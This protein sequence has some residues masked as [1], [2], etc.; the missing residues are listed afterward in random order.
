[1]RSGECRLKIG[2]CFTFSVIQLTLN[3]M[4]HNITSPAVFDGLAGV[5]E[6][7]FRA[8]DLVEQHAIVSP[9]QLCSSLL[10]KYPG[11]ITAPFWTRKGLPSI[12]DLEAELGKEK[13][14]KPGREIVG[15][16]K[17]SQPVEAD[18]KDSPAFGENRRVAH[19]C[20]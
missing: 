4:Y 1:M 20:A 13:P 7:F 11:F 18:N 3:L 8:F 2:N 14:A 6:A 16:F 5:P 10:H 12:E 19:H 9:R 15:F 17:P